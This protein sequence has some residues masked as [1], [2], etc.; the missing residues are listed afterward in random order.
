MQDAELPPGLADAQSRARQVPAWIRLP[1]IV[2]ALGGAVYQLVAQVG[3]AGWLIAA[4]A[5]MFGGK[6]YVMLTGLVT[7]LVM[8]V[9]AIILVQLLAGL[10]QP[11]S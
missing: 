8:L 5:A 6:Y 3:I 7:F 9:P 1:I 11:R 2:G 10:F 4:Q